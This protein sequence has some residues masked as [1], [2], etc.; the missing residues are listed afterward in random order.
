MTIYEC[1]LFVD[2][3]EPNAYTVDQKTRWVRECEGKI[4]TQL[5]GMQPLGFPWGNPFSYMYEELMLPAPWNKVYYRYLQ[6]MIHY[7]N[8]EYD[9]YA[10]SMQLFNEAWGELNR[11]FG[12]VYDV[13]DRWRNRRV[14]ISITPATGP[15]GD[16][17][18]QTLL[19][20]PERCAFIGGRVAVKKAYG[21]GEGEVTEIVGNVLFGPDA[22]AVSR[23]TIDMTTHPTSTR[24]PTLIAET[25]GDD[26]LF[27]MSGPSESGEAYLT[28]IVCV[29]DEDFY[30][31][32]EI[33]TSGVEIDG[34]EG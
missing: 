3:I 16:T 23:N 8:G 13:T 31:R 22:H 33:H 27:S 12:G 28:G 10:A 32:N 30:Y 5:F 6:A 34:S 4:Y 14:T 18:T 19:H 20:L 11:W 17:L 24:I 2:S 9:R 25:G 1:I 21:V 29:P 7:A 26:I 15:E